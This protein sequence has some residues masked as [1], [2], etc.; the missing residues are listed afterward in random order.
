VKQIEACYRLRPSILQNLA[1]L[2]PRDYP[3]K[4]GILAVLAIYLLLCEALEA[5]PLLVLL[6][7]SANLLSTAFFHG[8]SFCEVMRRLA[9]VP[10]GSSIFSLCSERGEKKHAAGASPAAASA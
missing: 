10:S 7:L 9:L 2:R 6:L 5:A 4:V 8:C 3:G 1:G